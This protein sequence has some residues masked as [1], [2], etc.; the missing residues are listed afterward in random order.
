MST[1]AKRKATAAKVAAKWRRPVAGFD[2]WR[3]P[4]GAKFHQEVARRVTGF[5]PEHFRHSKGEYAGQPFKLEPWQELVVGHTFAWKNPDGTRRFR[6]V[7]VY[8]PRKN[9]K[10]TLAAGLLLVIFTADGE[11]GAETYCAAADREQAA[12]V[13]KESCSMVNQDPAP[14]QDVRV[15][16]SYRTMEAAASNSVCRVLSS[17]AATKHGLNP[18]G[19]VVD[20]VHA[21]K[22]PD[23]MEVLETGVG[24]RRQPLGIYLTTADFARPSPCNEMVDYARKVRDGIIDDP[25]FLPVIYEAAVDADWKS[26]RVWKQANPNYGVSLKKE[27]MRQQCRKAQNNPSFENTF[28]RLHLNI[29]TEQET[30]WF[31]LDDWDAAGD[32]CEVEDLAGQE[33]FGGLD[34]SNTMDI[35]TIV[36]YFPAQQACLGW[37]WVPEQTR[38]QRIE[39][40]MWERQGFVECTRGAVIDYKFVRAKILEIAAQYA[41]RDIGYDPYNANQIV[42][43]LSDEDG[44]PMCEFRQGFLSMNAPSKELERMVVTHQLTHFGN[45]VLRWMASNVA[46]KEDPAGNIKPVK[47]A[48]NSPLKIDGI[49]GLVMGIGRSM[50]PDDEDGPSVYEEKEM[51]VI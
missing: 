51:L 34:L 32:A 3:D 2:P 23:L 1:R 40:E 18:H 10:S 28:K 5:F 49:V 13:F 21:Q 17:D 42:L 50:A 14:I 33:C 15:Y 35:T 47:P 30:R 20:E 9:G 8:V 44:L 12:L 31:S 6:K 7:F 19:Y 39:Y 36:L 26:E 45:P 46:I 29:Q 41:V 4:G 48:R 27:Y 25:Q 22:K 24:A 11:A 37:F 38:E 43:E 16:T